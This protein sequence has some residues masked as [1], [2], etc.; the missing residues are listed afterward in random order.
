MPIMQRAVKA[1]RKRALAAASFGIALTLAQAAEAQVVVYRP[2]PRR[3]VVRVIHPIPPG[4]HLEPRPRTELAIGG[5]VLT[6]IGVAL[7]G[8]AVFDASSRPRWSGGDEAAAIVGGLFALFG[9]P[10]L[11]TGLTTNKLVLVPNRAAFI[12]PVITKDGA[13]AVLGVSF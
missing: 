9:I 6:G 11:I 1:P 5:G 3:R 2:Y 12:A 7:I 10:M 8:G 4:F 13:S